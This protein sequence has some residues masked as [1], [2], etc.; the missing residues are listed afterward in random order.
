[1]Y[2]IDKACKIPWTLTFINDIV[3]YEFNGMK[4]IGSLIPINFVG[5]DVVEVIASHE[6]VFVEVGL[7]EDMVDFILGK[8]LSQ[9]SSNLLQ[10][11]HSDLS[12]NKTKATD[13]LTSKEDQTLSISARLSF[14]PS[15]AVA[16][17]KNSAK[18][19]PPDWSSSS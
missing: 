7:A 11:V 17:L 2:T 4:I 16:S 14:S 19:I 9:L 8:V 18:S 10:L 13:R 15:L 12:L 3:G 6:A 5:H 1:M